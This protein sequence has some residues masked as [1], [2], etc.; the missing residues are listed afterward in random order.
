MRDHWRNSILCNWSY[1]KENFNPIDIIDD[2]L[3][4]QLVDEDR[5]DIIN[6]EKVKRRTQVDL[7]L[8]NIVRRIDQPLKFSEFISILRQSNKF[9]ADQLQKE[10]TY[11]SNGTNVKYIVEKAIDNGDLTRFI[12]D[13]FGN[14]NIKMHLSPGK[15]YR[16]SVSLRSTNTISESLSETLSQKVAQDNPKLRII[17]ANRE[18]LEEEYDVLPLLN[19][20][21]DGSVSKYKNLSQEDASIFRNQ[22]SEIRKE[23]ERR[24]RV[25]QFLDIAEAKIDADTLWEFI[26][27]T[28]NAFSVKKL[29]D[30]LQN[31]GIS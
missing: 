19:A 31:S 1:L 14:E 27:D 10:K 4:V 18:M 9:I 12:A 17:K 2:L 21:I 28:G 24:K 5:A 15:K 13:I 29:K 11:E 20:V 3:G 26:E 22:L 7:T 30:D 8:R 16:V 25:Q 6:D 23:P